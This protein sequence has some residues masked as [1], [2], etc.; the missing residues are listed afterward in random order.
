MSIDPSKTGRIPDWLIACL[1][2]LPIV[3]PPKFEINS[4]YG[5]STCFIFVIFCLFCSGLKES[6][7]FANS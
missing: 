1:K 5:S 7:L 3:F 6:A 4:V 2:T